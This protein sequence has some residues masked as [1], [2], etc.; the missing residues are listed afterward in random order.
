MESLPRVLDLCLPQ[1]AAVSQSSSF[2]RTES[3][4][5]TP[6]ALAVLRLDTRERA[7]KPCPSH[8]SPGARDR[9]AHLRCET[10]PRVPGSSESRECILRPLAVTAAH[11]MARS[12][13]QIQR[14][15]RPI[16][17]PPTGSVGRSGAYNGPPNR[18]QIAPHE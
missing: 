8:L 14:H 3:S 10:P 17:S 2:W 11:G 4:S 7:H 13:A 15:A 16:D 1:L 6:P 12:P 5:S 18:G 9:A